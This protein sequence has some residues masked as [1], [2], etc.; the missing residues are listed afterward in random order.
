ML[1]LGKPEDSSS[2][3]F[4]N[5]T[6]VSHLNSEALN[7]AMVNADLVVCRSGFSTIL[8]LAKL[9][10]KAVFVPT[11]G[12]TEQ[13]YLASYFLENKRAFAMNQETFDISTAMMEIDNFEEI[14]QMNFSVDWQQLFAF[15]ERE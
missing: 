13:Q 9:N 6:V 11:P 14:K 2:N 10:K 15:F 3:V 5:L 4:G 1:V 7:Q 12:Q 8:D